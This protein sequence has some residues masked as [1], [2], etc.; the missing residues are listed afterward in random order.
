MAWNKDDW[1]RSLLMLLQIATLFVSGQNNSK[2][3]VVQT[4]AR[5]AAVAAQQAV[6]VALK[7]TP[8]PPGK[9][10]K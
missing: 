9:E 2:I 3:Q 8:T 6:E 4:E 5:S 1:K 10:V 7:A